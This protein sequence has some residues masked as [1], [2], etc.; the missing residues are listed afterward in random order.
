MAYYIVALLALASLRVPQ[1]LNEA[2][3]FYVVST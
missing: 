1:G 2:A 3:V